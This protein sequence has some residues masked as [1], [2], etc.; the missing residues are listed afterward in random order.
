MLCVEG[1]YFQNANDCT[2]DFESCLVIVWAIDVDD[3]TF[4]GRKWPV[5]EH[6]RIEYYTF[7]VSLLSQVI[8]DHLKYSPSCEC[9]LEFELYC[10][11]SVLPILAKI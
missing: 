8:G 7:M 9:F 5:E 6:K 10:W 3:F 4:E 11:C 1:S 2:N